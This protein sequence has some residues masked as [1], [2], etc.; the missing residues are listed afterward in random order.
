[1]SKAIRLAIFLLPV[2]LLT[3]ANADPLIRG[4]GR[5]APQG[6]LGIEEASTGSHA[7]LQALWRSALMPGWGQRY[8]GAPTRGWVFMGAEAGTW[9]VVGTFRI[10]SALRRADYI[11]MAEIHAGVSG[12]H[13]DD[14]WKRVGQ[15]DNAADYNEWLLRQARR[16]YGYGTAEYDSYLDENW[17]ADPHAWQWLSGDRRENYAEKRKGSLSAKRR[18][19]YT[20]Y[21]LLVN[22]VIATVDTWRLWK[23][24]ESIHRTREE[25]RGQVQAIALPGDQGLTWRLGWYRSF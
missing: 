13:D 1:M 11:E 21:A 6:K 20:L 5:P 7:L 17:E 8:L 16:E 15:F 12:S 3:A 22:R 2:L 14:F 18:A 19:T 9:T 24:S 23:T 4:E 10:Q 25:D